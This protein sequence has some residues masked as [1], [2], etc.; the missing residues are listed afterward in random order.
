[1]SSTPIY[2]QLAAERGDP[3]D[4]HWTE[5]TTMQTGVIARLRHTPH[6]TVFEWA[7][8]LTGVLYRSGMLHN[9]PM[10]GREP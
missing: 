10:K 9:P 7:D 2:D 3:H 1:M 5:I 8:T 6:G 4:G